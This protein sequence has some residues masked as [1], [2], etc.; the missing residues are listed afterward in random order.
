M[1]RN[2]ALIPNRIPCKK[3]RPP[4]L[5]VEREDKRRERPD[6]VRPRIAEIRGPKYEIIWDDYHVSNL[7]ERAKM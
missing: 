1:N 3:I 6:S 4:R 5:W 2:P 7:C